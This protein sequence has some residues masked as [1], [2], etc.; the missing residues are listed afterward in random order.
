MFAE[1]GRPPDHVARVRAQWSA[2]RPDLDTAPIGVLARLGRARAYVEHAMDEWLA[3]YGLN[4]TGWDVLLSLRREGPPYRLSPTRLYGGLMRTSGTITHRLR[5]LEAAGLVAR[6]PS[7]EDGRSVL[8]ELTPEG[9]ALVD[10]LVSEHLARERELLAP[11][12]ARQR[13][14]LADLL[15]T[16]LRAYEAD[17]D[18]PRRR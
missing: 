7:D 11:L 14:T 8:V 1:R 9:L 6:V 2:V 15:A 18:P 13:D 3:E 10:R 4:R 17:A 5:R 12:T 16:L